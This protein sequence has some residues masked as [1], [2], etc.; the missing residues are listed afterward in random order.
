[1]FKYISQ[2]LGNSK[3]IV[4]PRHGLRKTIFYRGG[5]FLEKEAPMQYKGWKRKT[6]K[7]YITHEL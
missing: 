3:H 6:S 4:R 7:R 2:P 1:M 5:L